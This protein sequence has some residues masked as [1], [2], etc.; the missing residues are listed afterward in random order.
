MKIRVFIFS[1]LCFFFVERE[2]KV[3][4][5]KPKAP[6]RFGFNLKGK[7]QKVTRIPFI[8]NSNL[9]VVKLRINNSDTL[10]FIL[11]TGVSSIII[12]DPL[13]GAKLNLKYARQVK[14]NGAGEKE[15]ITANVSIGHKIQ[16]GSVIAEKQNLVILDEDILK[17]SEFMGMPIHGIFGHELF[18]R[19]VVNIDFGR[20][21]IYIMEPE[22]F[23]FKK[24]YGDKFP[25]VVTQSKPYIDAIELAQEDRIFKSIRLVID[26]GAG[27]ALLLNTQDNSSITLPE[28]V[29]RANLGR[30][31]NGNIN[32]HIGRINEFRMGKFEFKNIL[33]S[34]PDSLSFSLKFGDKATQRQ[35]SVGGEFLRRFIVTFNYKE[36]YIALKPLKAKYKETFEH[37]MSGM[38]VHAKGTHFNEY[39]V[40]AV[41][42]DSQADK[43]GVK[44]GDQIIFFNAKQFN[45]LDIN[46]IYKLLSRKEGEEVELFLRRNGEL[47]FVY[48]KLRRII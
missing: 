11:D 3:F 34:F 1:L 39:F 32:G 21:E 33:A 43:A 28:T 47:K 25:I 40:S 6:E 29:I 13:L 27:H 48:F 41:T 18:V 30:G 19:F 31:L 23:K 5:Q 7:N 8:I 16:I 45:E 17:L 2:Q 4:A 15:F 26:T 36:G 44:E 10:N 38:E 14:I 35:G 9:I 46:D 22:S 24:S 12:I 20:R 37:D 42:P